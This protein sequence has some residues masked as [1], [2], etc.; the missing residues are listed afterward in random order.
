MNSEVEPKLEIYRLGQKRRR[1]VRVK[2][3]GGQSSCRNVWRIV[4]SGELSRIFGGGGLPRVLQIPM[5]D[6]MQRL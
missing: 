3:F 4:R 5:H 6:D 2:Y 1:I